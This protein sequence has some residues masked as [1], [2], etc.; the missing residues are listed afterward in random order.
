MMSFHCCCPSESRLG[1][2][3][4]LQPEANKAAT[5][6][7]QASEVSTVQLQSVQPHLLFPLFIQLLHRNKSNAVQAG[8]EYA[9]LPSLSAR[10]LAALE[11]KGA[12]W[13]PLTH[14]T[15]LPNSII[16]NNQIYPRRST[17]TFSVQARTASRGPR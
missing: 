9:S 5:L 17:S 12:L 8:A 14:P 10:Y 1:L 3:E 2:V 13:A 6:G 16:N 7:L 4:S 11:R 15:Y